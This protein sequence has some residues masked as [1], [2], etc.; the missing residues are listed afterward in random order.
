M[1]ID[2]NGSDE[3]LYHVDEAQ[4]EVYAITPDGVATYLFRIGPQIGYPLAE[5][6]GNGICH[7]ETGR[8]EYLYI[9]DIYP[10]YPE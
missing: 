4:G 7:V 1:G 5:E 2:W 6:I 3:V 9:T 10:N 8:G